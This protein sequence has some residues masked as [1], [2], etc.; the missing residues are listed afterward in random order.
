MTARRRFYCLE[1]ELELDPFEVRVREGSILPDGSRIYE[2]GLMRRADPTS[3]PVR[4][5]EAA[6]LTSG[7]EWHVVSYQNVDT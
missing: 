2:H 5:D 3:G 6:A 7:L 4:G 1:C